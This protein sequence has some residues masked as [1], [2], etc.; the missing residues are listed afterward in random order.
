MTSQQG[1]ILLKKQLANV[2]NFKIHLD[3]YTLEGYINKTGKNSFN[4]TVKGLV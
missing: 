4:I 3:L 1:K 2:F